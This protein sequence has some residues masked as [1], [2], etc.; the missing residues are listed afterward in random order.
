[1]TRSVVVGL[2]VLVFGF[3]LAGCHQTDKASSSES[4]GAVQNVAA[5]ATP[6]AEPPAP[7]PYRGASNDGAFHVTYRPSPDPIPL[8]E[9]FELEVV[10]FKDA[11]FR[12]PA[13]NVTLDVDAAMPQHQHGMNQQP[14]V[15]AMGGGRFSGKNMLFHMS[16]YWELYFDVTEGPVTE[17]A[18]FVIQ[19]D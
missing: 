12:Q 18:Q 16:G 8:N 7:L 4:A 3:S 5:S 10:V 15:E 13:T 14:T 17:R 1:M 9:P 6:P 11:D 19:L 2:S